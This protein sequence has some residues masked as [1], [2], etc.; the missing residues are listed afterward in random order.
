VD[1]RTVFCIIT[2]SNVDKNFSFAHRN[3]KRVIWHD[4]ANLDVKS[5]FIADKILITLSGLEE[6]INNIRKTKYVIYR[7]PYMPKLEEAK[8]S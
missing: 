6:L 2:S 3:I 7:Q 4:P 8:E 5:L 1:D